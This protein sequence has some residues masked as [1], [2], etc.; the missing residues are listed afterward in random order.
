M[1]V[2]KLL[3]GSGLA[4]AL[5]G[6]GGLLTSMPAGAWGDKAKTDPKAMNFDKLDANHDG[7]ISK[8]EAQGISG[9]PA[10]F[11]QTDANKDGKLDRGEFE[12]AHK[13]LAQPTK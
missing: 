8:P 11:D 12:N 2:R 7:Y 3:L 4:L 9:L 10:V 13:Q 1:E 6:A 5:L